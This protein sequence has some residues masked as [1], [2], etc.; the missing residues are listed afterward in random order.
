MLKGAFIGRDKDFSS[1]IILFPVPCFR[2]DTSLSQKDPRKEFVVLQLPKHTNDLGKDKA[3]SFS[4]AGEIAT[5]LRQRRTFC[6]Q[7]TWVAEVILLQRAK[8]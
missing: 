1:T 4:Q 7:G 2:S 8:V 5:P 6:R 3:A